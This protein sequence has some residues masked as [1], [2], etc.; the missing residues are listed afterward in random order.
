[1]DTAPEPAAPA[2]HDTL[3]E[4][5]VLNRDLFF[6]VRI[7]NALRDAGYAVTF[8][9][10][11]AAFVAAVRAAEPPAV[12]GLIDLGAGPDWPEIA[13]LT[14]DVPVTPILV[15]GPH[16]D[17]DGF[18]AAKAAGITR[19]VSNGDFH[20]DMLGLIQRYARA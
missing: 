8:R 5:V 14:R 15:F 4:I 9:P 17:V 18:R 3:P 6:G 1:M 19:I 20:R 12:L 2:K 7:G 11:T 10:A 13:R 16:K